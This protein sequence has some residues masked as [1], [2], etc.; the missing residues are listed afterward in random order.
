[1]P[2]RPAVSMTT[3][4]KCFARASARPAAATSTGSPGPAPAISGASGAVPGC[5]ANTLTPARSPTIL[6]WLTAPGRCRSQATSKGVWPCP[7]SH[8][9]SLPASVVFPA[10]CRPASMITV[11]GVFAKNS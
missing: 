6:S 2:S 4:S 8:R 3:T 5:G 9:A 7:R 1:M 11:G 10:P